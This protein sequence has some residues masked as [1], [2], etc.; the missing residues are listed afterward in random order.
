MSI[1]ITQGMI[2][3]SYVSN[4]QSSLAAYMNSAEQGSSQKKVNTPSDDPAGMYTILNLRNSQTYNQRL[5]ENCDTAKGWLKMEDQV[6][7]TQ[8]PT[9]ISSIK[10]LAEQ[11]STGTYTAVQRK[12]IA[13][14]VRQQFGSVLNLSNTEFNGKTLFSGHKYDQPAFQEGLALSS[15]DSSWNTQISLG[16]YTLEGNAEST[17]AFQFE[18]DGT[19]AS[20]LNYRWTSDGGDNWFTGTV[21]LETQ[22][23]ALGDTTNYIVMDFNGVSLKITEEN[24]NSITVSKANFSEEGVDSNDGTVY[25]RPTAYYQGD[26]NDNLQLSFMGDNGTIDQSTTT[27]YGAFHGNTLIRFDESLSFGSGATCHWSYSTDNGMNW[28]DA[29]AISSDE[30]TIRLPLPDGYI[31]IDAKDS[32]TTIPTGAQIMIHPEDADIEYEIMKD[33]YITVNGV[34]K[35]IFGG[36]YYNGKQNVPAFHG[37]MPKA[38]DTDPTVLVGQNGE[39]FIDRENNLFEIIG[40]FIAALETNNQNGCGEALVKL[41]K[42]EEYIL[43][44][45]TKVGGLENRVDVAYDV[46][47]SQKN[48]IKERL[49]YVEDIDLT[50]LLVKMQQQ[51]ITYQTVLQSASKIMNLS[52]ANY[53]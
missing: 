32:G 4:M 13:Y 5:M 21:N 49:S 19:L 46:L 39:E 42:A 9:V 35:D 28:V 29:T 27:A 3:G 20:G 6:L 15:K 51:Q 37:G 23:N 14:Q 31:D 43:M 38:D 47:T 30:S 45:S 18:S 34:G 26:V 11:A 12:E 44:Q 8:L 25:I 40:D 24:A 10:E 22:T 2:Y 17:I 52:L 33:A 36:Y 48:D 16:N 1:R 53:L 41:T 7:A 50:E